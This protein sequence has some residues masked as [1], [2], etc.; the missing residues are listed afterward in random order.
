ASHKW[1]REVLE[2][3]GAS[4]RIHRN[5][6]VFLLADKTALDALAAA[7]RTYLGWK[8]VQAT[9]DSLNLTNQQNK[10][11]NDNVTRHDQT[12]NDRLRDAYVWAV[13]PEQFD[14][15]KTFELVADKVSD[16]SARSLAER[17]SVKLGREDQLITNYGP[18]N[19]GEEVLGRLLSKSMEAGHITVGELWGYFTRYP[20]M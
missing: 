5:S 1:I 10:Q 15:T 8:Q 20:Y 17:V 18:A 11:T 9:S 7:T 14:P 19:L 16:S 2:N 13:Y 4:Q 12:V 6:L 3:K